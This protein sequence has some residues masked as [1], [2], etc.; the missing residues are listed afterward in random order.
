[1]ARLRLMSHNQWKC[2]SNLPA[3]EE[4]GLDC[5]AEVRERGFVR[6][7]RDTMP[8]VI[9]CQE[10]SGTMADLMIRYMQEEGMRY[11]LLWG[12]DTPIV[13]RQDKFELVDSD[14]A[15][16]PKEF[17]GYEGEFNNG[18]TKSWCLAVFRVKENGKL[19]LFV[20]THLWWK[21][22]N[23]A[24]ANYQKGSGEARAY[25]LGL[26]IAKIDEFQKKYNCPAV[27]VG[28]FNTA[29]ETPVIR[30]AFEHGFVHA[31]DVAVEFADESQ[32]YH[33]CGATGFKP[34][35]SSGFRSA[36][37]HIL[38]RGA[39]A[40]FVRRFERFSPDYYLPLSDHSPVF[41]DVEL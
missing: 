26:V 24:S 29:Y 32:G 10:V 7:F 17:P 40:G 33:S 20:S 9:G 12:R 4:Q 34:Y 41:V 38:V 14:F 27:I 23:P 13:Y 25:Q 5:S 30:R 39:D 22:D 37:D 19:F 2:D 21:S 3:W 15:L 18:N 35:L 8:D 6:V 28:D 16:Y 36:I 31:H 11:A 1:M